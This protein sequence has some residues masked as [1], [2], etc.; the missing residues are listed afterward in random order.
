MLSDDFVYLCHVTDGLIQGHN[1]SL[2]VGG[3]FVGR[4]S[5]L[6]VFEPLLTHLIAADVEVPDR[7]RHASE[8]LHRV[9]PDA[10]VVVVVLNLLDGIRSLHRKL[11]DQVIQFRR[12]HEM[13]GDKVPENYGNS[14][15]IF[16]RVK[17]FSLA[18]HIFPML[19]AVLLREYRKRRG[20]NFS[21]D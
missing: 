12:F 16:L 3:G 6:A 4:F 13:K 2:V 15:L 1:D 7:R 5:A 18:L 14:L 9:N 17:S 10:S 8:V 19:P 21:Y 11:S 20:D